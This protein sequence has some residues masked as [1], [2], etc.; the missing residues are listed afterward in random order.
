MTQINAKGVVTLA[1]RFGSCE[2]NGRINPT[3]QRKENLFKKREIEYVGVK[4]AKTTKPIAQ[5]EKI[6]KV[7]RSNLL[8]HLAQVKSEDPTVGVGDNTKCLQIH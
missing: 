1:P 7:S 3:S 8:P 5:I 6:M 2:G 4:L